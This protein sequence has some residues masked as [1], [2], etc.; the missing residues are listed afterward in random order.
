MC[1]RLPLRAGKP[2]V[3]VPV[4]RVLPHLAHNPDCG[5]RFAAFPG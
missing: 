3:K 4:E 2:V 5:D 1:R